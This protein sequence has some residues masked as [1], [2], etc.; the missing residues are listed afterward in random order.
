MTSSSDPSRRLARRASIAFGALTALAFGLI[1]LGA[2]VRAHGAGLAC[3][4]WPLCFGSVI[5]AFNFGVA[6]EWGHRALAGTLTLGVAASSVWVLRDRSLR[7]A[8]ARVLAV[9]GVLLGAQIVLGGFTV[10][11]GLA[12]WTVT[13]HLLFGNALCAALLWCSRSLAEYGSPVPAAWVP[14]HVRGLALAAGGLV[15]LQLA[16]GGLVS[17]H[18]AG[19]ACYD[20][21]SCDGVSFA[22]AFTGLVGLHVLHRLGACSVALAFILLVGA[23]WGSDEPVARIARSGLRLI[24]LQVA[25]GVANVLLR[26]PVE[27]TGL[28]SALAAALVLECALLVREILLHRAERAITGGAAHAQ[29]LGA[30]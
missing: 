26:L 1:V 25:V 6:F 10:L 20:F 15:V 8:V 11:L 3:P 18:Y 4:D 7:P 22:P 14:A 30:S 2:L 21:P 27:M 13:A 24:A 29:P 16:L 12:P 28:H 23:T 19:L 17:S 5:P 9:I